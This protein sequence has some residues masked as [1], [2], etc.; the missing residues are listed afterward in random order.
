MLKE[1]N[2]EQEILMHATRDKYLK[3]FFSL[4]RIDKP[5]A[6]KFI[7]WIYS[8]SGLKEPMV[9]FVDSPIACQIACNLIG[10]DEVAS[11]LWIQIWNQAREQIRNQVDE[12][13][14]RQVWNQV[15]SQAASQVRN[16]IWNQL[17]NQVLEQVRNQVGVKVLNE[18]ENQVENQVWNQV[19]NK[20]RNQ[21]REQV[22][23]QVWNQAR[24]RV[25]NQVVSQ[26]ENQVWNQVLN[27]VLEQV[28]NQVG[29]KVL[30]EVENQAL[31]Q[32]ENQVLNQ[33]R[34][35]VR[36]Q[37]GNQVVSQV[38][39]QVRNQVVSQV[40]NQVRNQVAS[41]VWNQEENQ[42]E[43]QVWN[44]VRNRVRSQIWG[45]GLNY[46]NFGYFA[47]Y[48]D[49]GW[50]SF[51]D[52]FSQIGILKNKEFNQYKKLIDTGIFATIQMDKLCIVSSM[53][54]KICRSGI[55]L[56]N[57]DGYAVE[58]ADGYGQHY[59]YGVYFSPEDFEKVKTMTTKEALNIKN[60][61]QRMAILKLFGAEKIL[62]EMGA[63]LID[64][65]ERGNKLYSIDG[66][67]SKTEKILK[68][69]CP[70]T[71]R[72]YV[73]FVKPHYEN[74]DLAQAESHHFTL[75]QYNNLQWEA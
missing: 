9:L 40:E 56:H 19:R 73:K 23:N 11:Q 55:K 26:V 50:V 54:T 17:W 37:V 45:K 58:F 35:R 1:L 16:Q 32:V 69:V 36:N 60:I 61:E 34:N 27:Q 7:K 63:K 62:N 67:T 52:F 44:K 24:N 30:N 14:D 72:I 31:E 10:R 75:E 70:S 74:A 64:S 25:R 18:V 51:Y 33:A 21:A 20:V 66:I 13:I 65:S 15:E 42:V 28:R 41:Q 47:D 48:S 6:T 8:L 3:K 22:E 43:N 4:P 49:F 59:L 12:Q 53:P 68:Y 39:N 29:G 71:G 38:E 46:F 57:P 2:Q 5:K